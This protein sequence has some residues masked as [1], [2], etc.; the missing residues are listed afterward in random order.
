MKVHLPQ[1]ITILDREATFR[2]CGKWVSFP[3]E[4]IGAPSF[5]L[6]RL[7]CR[8]RYTYGKPVVGAVKA[9]FCRKAFAFY[10]HSREEP[11][12]ICRTY[13]LTVRSPGPGARASAAVR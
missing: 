4:G 1:V 12:D 11:K 8:R 9:D 6:T 13:Q 5:P 10:W 7:L 2:I 3:P